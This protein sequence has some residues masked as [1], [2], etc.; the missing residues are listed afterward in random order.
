MVELAPDVRLR[1]EHKRTT[2]RGSLSTGTWI[3]TRDG[4]AFESPFVSVSEVNA[5]GKALRLDFYDPHHLDRA[6]AR[7]DEIGR[8]EP[9]GSPAAGA[10]NASPGS[11]LNSREDRGRHP[12]AAIAKP[13]ALDT[14]L[15]RFQ[16]AYDLSFE[17]GDWSTLGQVC[18]PDIVFEDRRRL[19]LVSGGL[20]LLVDSLR[21]RAETGARGESTI[22]GSAGN[23]VAIMRWLWSGGP[24]D[25]RFEIEYLGVGEV[26]E[27]GRLGAIILFDLEDTGA[28]QREAWARWAKIEPE[29]AETLATVA[30][31]SGG[32]KGPNSE[33]LRTKLADDLIVEDR[34]R[35][36]MGHIEG[37]DAYAQSVAVLRQLAPNTEIELGWFWPVIGPQ[38]GVFTVRRTGE[39][40]GGGDYESDYL[41]LL[42]HT[43]GQWKRLEFFELEELDQARA[44][45][46]ELVGSERR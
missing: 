10:R 16:A 37:G 9:S 4:G 42:V 44:R 41:A 15:E 22:V 18:A 28:A 32:F 30:E 39:I 12:F 27:A 34:R 33:R 46:E 19:A 26:D 2:Q 36:G 1:A 35:T 5:E 29:I 7:L 25:G 38:G 23:R 3:G 13:D 20:E 21:Q 40:A 43:E 31:A 17:S 8:G 11:L 24:P 6:L 14:T 45:F